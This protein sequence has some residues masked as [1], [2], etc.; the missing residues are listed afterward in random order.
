M[1]SQIANSENWKY[2]EEIKKGYS[3]DKK[4]LVEESSNKRLLIRLSN[5]EKYEEKKKEFLIIQKYSRLGFSMSMPI[6]FGICNDNRNVYMIL[7]YLD[8]DNLKD[9]LPYLSKQEQYQLG[10][11]AGKILKTIHTLELDR[12]DIPTKTKKEKKL[13][14]L[15]NYEESNLRINGDEEVIQFVKDNI[16][17]IWKEKPVYQHGDF[18]PA[19]M[20]YMENGDIGIIDFNR[21]EVGDPYEEFC[22]LQPFGIECSIP[23]SIGQIEGYFNDDIPMYFWKANAVYAAHNALVSIKWA[24]SFGK[25]EVN[26]MMKRAENTF[27]D[28]DYFK[29]IIPKWYSKG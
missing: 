4:Y 14:Q 7:S 13:L 24:E 11:K 5:I 3:D 6:E 19:N 12:E 28:F 23:Y 17:D 26:K 20:I 18:H 22:R 8:G 21:W 27:K 2:I 10:R 25:E 15:S 29:N 9:K 1:V 16:D